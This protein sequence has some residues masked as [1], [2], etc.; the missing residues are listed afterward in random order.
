MKIEIDNL[1]GEGVF[2]LLEEHLADMHATSPPESIHALDIKSLKSPDIMFWCARENGEALGC[3]ALKKLTPVHAEIKSMRTTEAIRGK[4]VGSSLLEHLLAEVADRGYESVSLETGSQDFFIP[5][6]RLY[7]R[8]GFEYCEP[9]SD[10]KI[11][12]NS[13][14]MTLEI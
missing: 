2:K 1:E 3:I 9:F 11:D 8:F 4:G 13:L 12:P 5:A 6:R 14:F 10:Y 7:E